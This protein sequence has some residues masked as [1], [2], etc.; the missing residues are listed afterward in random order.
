MALPWVH[1]SSEDDFKK[2]RYLPW[3]NWWQQ[4]F[5]AE[6]EWL[7]K[8]CRSGWRCACVISYDNAGKHRIAARG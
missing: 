3:L 1:R 7:M 6:D 2:R 8:S 4:R 5:M